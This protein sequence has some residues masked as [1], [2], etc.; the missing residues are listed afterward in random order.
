MNKDKNIEIPL[1]SVCCLTYNMQ[2]YVKQAIESIL[3]QRTTFVYEIIIH[4][5]A[6]TDDTR[7][8]IEEYVA[9]FPH[10]IRP[11]Y[12]EEN[13]Y[14]KTGFKFH[15]EEVIPM[16]NGKYIAFCD[17]DDYWI[18]P[19]KL[20]KQ[21][22]FLE[23]NPDYGMVHTKAVKFREYQNIFKD[24][25][26]FDFEN[27]EELLTECTVLHSSVCYLN[28]LAMQY[29]KEIK[30]QEKQ[31][32]TTN[33]FPMWLFFI[34]HY[35]I[36]LLE[37]ITTVYRE[38]SESVSHIGDDIKRLQFSEG[39]YDIVDFYLNQFQNITNENKIR[40][41]YY[42][43]MIKMYF[44]TRRWDDIRKSAKIF[45]RANDWLNIFWIGITLPFFYST[46]MVKASYKIR[47]MVFDLFNIYPIRK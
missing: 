40:A 35:K 27:I 6:S 12:Q 42:S 10:I 44:L 17:G 21:V 8:I 3:M 13:K 46:F 25:A 34:Q 26:G 41:R 36:K 19:L 22:D 1:V 33:D 2:E 5:D 29:L 43:D 45:Y 24:S 38:R 4:D 28:S 20:Q 30:P 14:S 9:S 11:I 39:V 37:D 32:W 7:E 16:A 15:Y 23:S 18:D 47:S 31:N